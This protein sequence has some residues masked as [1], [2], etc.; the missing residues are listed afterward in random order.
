MSD[1]L[2]GQVIEKDYFDDIK[3]KISFNYRISEMYDDM[4]REYADAYG[5]DRKAY[6]IR[7][8][9][10]RFGVDYY[11]LQKVKDIVAMNLCG[12]K[13]CLNCQSALAAKRQF[14]YA[15]MLDCFLDEYKICHTV[16]TVKNPSAIMFKATLNK[17]YEKFAYFIRYLDG[18]KKIKG[19]DFAQYGYA[20]CLRALEVTYNDNTGEYHPHFHCMLLMKKDVPLR[21]T[22]LTQFSY[23]HGVE[24]RRFS[25][26]EV[27]FQKVWYLLMNDIKV[28]KQSIEALKQGYS[29]TCDDSKGKYHEVFKYCCKGAFNN[30]GFIYDP[31]VFENLFFGLFNR[32]MIQT[33]GCLRCLHIE[34]D[35]SFDDRVDEEYAKVIDLLRQF[36]VPLYCS[37]ELAEFCKGKDIKYI[38][39]N[40]I[41]RFLKQIEEQERAEHGA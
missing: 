36:E 18:R 40:S 29:V 21:K 37:C 19:V 33:Y 39:R 20:G 2:K 24:E 5:F 16:F 13:F 35:E 8:C 22:V 30:D 3:H 23:D 34:E 15:P 41:R 10:T 31:E 14:K 25:K 6:R 1:F 38:S 17:M 4:S 32:R 12:D 27:L 7:D 28:T 11:R 26:L 9:C